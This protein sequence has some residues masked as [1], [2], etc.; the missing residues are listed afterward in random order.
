GQTRARCPKGRAGADERPNQRAEVGRFI[1]LLAPAS[2]VPDDPPLRE[3]PLSDVSR[4][5]AKP[6]LRLP[7]L[8]G[9]GNSGTCLVMRGMHYPGL[10]GGEPRDY[11]LLY[12]EF[13]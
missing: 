11:A 10:L 6:L 5:R 9:T 13:H 7:R 4:V 3:E 12:V 2:L 1:E 8:S